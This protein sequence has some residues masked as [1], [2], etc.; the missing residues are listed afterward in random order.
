MNDAKEKAVKDAVLTL[1]V[2]MLAG[3]YEIPISEMFGR[4]YDAGSRDKIAE[5]R[6]R[7]VEEM[8]KRLSA[9]L[10][11]NPIMLMIEV[12]KEMEAERNV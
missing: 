12:E 7:V 11:V 9:R 2:A 6:R 10:D 5:Y 8:Q 4:V 1:E 3:V